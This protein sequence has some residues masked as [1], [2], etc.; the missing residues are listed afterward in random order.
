MLNNQ[1]I[2]SIDAIEKRDLE[3]I[4]D[5]A[6]KY[7]QAG[8]D[9]TVLKDTVVGSLF[10]ETSTRTRLSFETAIQRLGG[11]VVGFA[12]SGST[13]MS[14]KGESFEDTIRMVDGFVDCIVMRHPNP[15]SAKIAAEVARVPVINAG[16]GANEHPTQTMLDLYTIIKT[17]GTL[18]NLTI[19][20]VGDLKYGRVPHSLAKGLSHWPSSKQIWVAP[21]SLAMPTAVKQ[22]VEQRG[23]AVTETT[24][25]EDIIPEV[26]I[27]LMTRVQAERFEDS[28][29]YEKVKDVYVLNLD[30]LARA[31]DN[32]KIIHPLPRRYEIPEEIDKSSHA[33]YFQQA[34]NGV[35][36]RAALLS[37][38]LN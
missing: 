24:N 31:Q 1:D 5:L 6:A 14:K 21:K 8:Y 27:L 26:D 22:Y 29:E 28:A 10:F 20:L 37:L 11:K 19:G 12:D 16:D 38:I 23:V 17:Q 18:E 15:G 32:M 4:L 30:M 35:P 34:R 25:L 7:D 3:A 9:S 33:H 13:S 36:T 2:I